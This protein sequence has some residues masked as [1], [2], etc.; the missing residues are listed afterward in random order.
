M[1]E[2]IKLAFMRFMQGRYGADKFSRF[3][4]WFALAL[5]VLALI[6]AL[7]F[8][9]YLG[10]V[11]LIFNLFRMFSRNAAK[12]AQENV[13]YLQFSGKFTE[14]FSQTK[15]RFKNRKEYKY[16]RCPKCHAWLKLKRGAGEGTLTCGKCK[17]S[18]KAKA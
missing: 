4:L 8:L 1:F 2:K 11:L 13:K 7:W 15:T 16:F 17:H 10:L 12:R 14:G 9:G 6:P 3:L 18:F 5:Y